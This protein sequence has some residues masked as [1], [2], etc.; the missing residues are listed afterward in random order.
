VLRTKPDQKSNGRVKQYRPSRIRAEDGRRHNG[1]SQSR[2]RRQ[3]SSTAEQNGATDQGRRIQANVLL[4]KGDAGLSDGSYGNE[5]GRRNGGGHRRHNGT[6]SARQDAGRLLTAAEAPGPVL[7]LGPGPCM[8]N[9]HSPA[10][11]CRRR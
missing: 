8:I 10:S 3:A 6:T 9:L 5:R 2:G 4:M 7:G 11:L 1:L